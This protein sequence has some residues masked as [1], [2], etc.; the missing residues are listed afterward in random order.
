MSENELNENHWKELQE[1]KAASE[2][3]IAKYSKYEFSG[4]SSLDLQDMLYLARFIESFAPTA[5]NHEKLS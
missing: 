5:V 1:L 4:R 3:L 2:R